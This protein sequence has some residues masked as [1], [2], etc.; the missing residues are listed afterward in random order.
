MVAAAYGSAPMVDALIE[1]GSDANAADKNCGGQTILMWAARSGREAKKK[2]VSLLKAGANANG[3]SDNG[4]NALMS[5]AYSG[6]IEAV[7]ALLQA[8]CVARYK[9]KD[10]T[11]VLMA[12]A[13]SGKANVVRLLI[14]AGAE[15]N[16]ADGQGMTALMKAVEGYDT[17]G[18]VEALLKAGADP[19]QKNQQGKT[20][21]EMAQ[22]SDHSGASQVVDALKPVTKLK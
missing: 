14:K 13:R 7:E 9:T 8:G 4:W 12:G 3:T 20:A 2:I 18:A 5:A 17:V 1:A 11:T 15:V 21:L 22:G 10:G 19:N 6:D 16:S